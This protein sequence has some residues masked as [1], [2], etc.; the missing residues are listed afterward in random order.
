MASA[1]A[2]TLPENGSLDVR[3]NGTPTPLVGVV[4]T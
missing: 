1:I 4:A 2:P 3:I